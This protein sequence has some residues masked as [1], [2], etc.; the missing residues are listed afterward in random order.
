MLVGVIADTHDRVPMIHAA[1]RCFED[2]RI[3]VLI[4][5]GD[6][7]S[8][9][10]A[11][12]LKEF[13]GTIYVIYGNNDGERTG[14]KQVLPQIQ[15]GPL[16]VKLN[17]CAILVHHY[18]GWCRQEDVADCDVVISGHTHSVVTE[19]RDGRLYLNPGEACGWL[20]DRCTVAVLDTS[21]PSAEILELPPS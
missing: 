20:S 12:A 5:A 1:L 4:H 13:G 11:K 6:L 18:V 19:V 16:R 14:L 9:F 2:R 17:G 7:V 10:A 15:D 8:P 3:N 21:I